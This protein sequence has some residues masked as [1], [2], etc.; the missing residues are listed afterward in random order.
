MDVKSSLSIIIRLA[1]RNVWKN[2]RRTILTLLTIVVGMTVILFLNSLAKGGHDQMIEDAV[3]VNAG[4]IQI[5]EK[6]FWD[7]RSIEYAFMPDST[8]LEMLAKDDR[9]SAVSRRVH[10]G[11][12]LSFRDTTA[13]AMIQAVEPDAEIRVT[14]MHSM[15]LPGGRYL[16]QGDSR[17]IVIGETLAKNLGAGVGDSID[18]ISQG[19]DGSIAAENLTIVG[20]VR[21]GNPEYDRL[22]VVMT[23]DH[24]AELFTMMDYITSI[25]LRLK[26]TDDVRSLRND[27]R[28]AVDTDALEVMGWD[29]LMP[30]LVQFIVLDDLGAYIFD[31]ILFMVV[32]FGILN[33]IQMSVFDRIREFGVMLAIGTRPGQVRAMVLCESVFISMLG[34]VLGLAAGIALSYYFTV[35]PLD[36]SQYAEEIKVWG[37]STTVFP[38][39]ITWLN[40]TVTTCLTFALSLLFTLFP[41]HRASRLK[42]IEA[43][44]HL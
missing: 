41:A 33:T 25:T 31:F 3:A 26:D 28:S 24:A 40:L 5:H 18:L 11:G 12:L 39:R 23:M 20:L 42:P 8:L 4:H 9:V 37:V 6:G 13:G 32:A 15:V 10:A 22:L 16:R 38:T 35:N 34:I 30:E 1:W 43:I 2:R 7:N 17:K 36:Y 29:D 14:T 27:I 19:F 44:R 21:T